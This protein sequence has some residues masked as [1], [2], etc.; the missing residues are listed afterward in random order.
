MILKRLSHSSTDSLL[1]GLE[2]VANQQKKKKMEKTTNLLF[3]QKEL[4]MREVTFTGK[5]ILSFPGTLKKKS[6][7]I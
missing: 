4:H 2:R 6:N 1:C 7:I 3:L 5:G